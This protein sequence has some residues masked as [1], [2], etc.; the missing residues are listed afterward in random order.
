MVLCSTLILLLK[1]ADFDWLK[2]SM[3]EYHFEDYMYSETNVIWMPWS[4]LIVS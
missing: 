1:M 4:Q 2:L 3:I